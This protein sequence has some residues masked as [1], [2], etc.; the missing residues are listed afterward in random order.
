VRTTRERK[1]IKKVERNKIKLVGLINIM[2]R[3]R[4]SP[5]H[6]LPLFLVLLLFGST[7]LA[8]GSVGS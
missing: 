3:A 1:E 8:V 4:L 5:S 6:T 7:T 2:P